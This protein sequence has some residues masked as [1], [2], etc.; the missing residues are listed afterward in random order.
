M[1]FHQTRATVVTNVHGRQTKATKADSK[2][3]NGRMR[4]RVAMP[5]VGCGSSPLHPSLPLP[6]S[7]SVFEGVGVS[8]GAGTQAM[9]RRVP[10]PP[11]PLPSLRWRTGTSPH[12]KKTARRGHPSRS[13]GSRRTR[14]GG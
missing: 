2:N 10:S 14:R 9:G 6:S 8:D 12:R 3:V 7:L 4:L 11:L 5:T 13:M 1:A